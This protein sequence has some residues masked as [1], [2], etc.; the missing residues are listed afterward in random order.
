VSFENGQNG[1]ILGEFGDPIE[2]RRNVRNNARF[3]PPFQGH[4]EAPYEEPWLGRRQGRQ[5]GQQAQFEPHA[6]PPRHGMHFGDPKEEQWG[7]NDQDE[8]WF[9]PGGGRQAR[10]RPRQYQGAHHRDPY[11]QEQDG[12]PWNQGRA[13]DPRPM[14]LDFPRFKGGDPTAWV[15]RAL[16]YFHYYQVPEP[17]KVMHASYHLDEEALVWFQDCE[18]EL[19][20][21]NDFVRA[22]QIRFGPASYDDPMELLTKL[23]QTHSIAAYKSQFELTSNRVRDLSNM[24]KLSCFMSCMKDEIRLAVK[25]QGPRNLGEA[26]A[27]AKIQEEYLAT[28]KRSTRPTYEPSRGAWVQSQ[29][30][31]RAA[32][33]ENKSGDS[34]QFSA[35]PSMLVQRLTPMQMS[36]RRKK[37]LC[38]NCD[39]RWSSDHKCK[40]RKLYLMEEVED[41]EA[42]LVEIEEEEVEAELEEAKAEITLCAL[43]GS[44]SPSTMR[45]IAI[46]NGQTTVVLLDTGSTHNFMDETLA[47][48]LKLPMDGE[49]NFG[50]RVANGQVI[51]TL[52][53]CKE[54]KFKMQGLH[55]KLTFNLLE[56]GGYGIVLGTQWLSTLGMINWDFKNLMMGFMHEGKQVWLQGLKEKPNLIQGSK[57]FK[58]KATMKGLLFQIMPCEL[59]SIQEE[60]G[61]PIRE[62]VEEFPQVFEEPEG[63]PPKRNH[64]HQI[65]LKHET[66]KPTGLLQPLGIPPRPWHTISMD[67]VEGLP[68]S[69][70]QNVI[71]VI[72]D[73][74]TKYVH[75]IPLSHPCTV[76]RVAF[77][78]LQH[79]FKLHGLSSSI[80]SDRDTAFTSLFWEEL[81]R[82]QGVDLTMSSS[83]YP[84]SDEPTEVVNKS[85]EHYLRA[86]AADKPS[87]WV[88]WLP[89]AEYWFNTNYHTSTKLSPF[90]ALYGYLPPRLIE[91]VLGLTR[92]AAVE[93]LLEHR[94]QVVGLLEH[95]LVAA[96]ARMKQQ[97]DKHRSEREFEVGDWV[98]LRLQPFRQ[99]SMC[100]KLGKLSPKFYGPYKVIQRVGMVA[101]K[102]EL[103]EGACI[104]PVFHVSFLKAKLGKTITPISRIPPTDALGHLAPQPAKILE[105]RTIK[106]R[107]L[108]AVTEVLVQWE[109]EDPDDATWELLFKLQE[110][111]PHLVGK[112]F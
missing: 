50:V 83:Y 35:R 34:K 4:F 87:L 81:F 79:V 3:M 54:V 90:E 22:I 41:E 100:K 24:H 45:V 73:R 78:F 2:E 23:K 7:L 28:V 62:L 17:E 11:W 112:V 86:F 48:T 61:A 42:E 102:L 16:Q 68:T 99:K 12:P 95:N 40:D 58:G 10:E 103:P 59:A 44:T 39:E 84:Q 5:Q 74:F 80:V 53:E 9:D 110:D 64:E 26:Y 101:Y 15:Y 56:L 57:D 94:Q 14:K 97:A 19:H 92:V 96:Q 76:S 20:G 67:F 6:A 106:K 65:L 33:V 37:G 51:R 31:Q 38:Y 13:R 70:K 29:A 82:R 71:L 8:A 32:Q 1:P 108:P 63:L 75:F 49:S 109:G 105:T 91:F 89:L 77:L 43:L 72:V 104:H 93:D 111:Y 47:K 66:S 25:M 52:G 85:L 69:S 60:I 88:E 27:L 46:V 30:Q 18:H 36:E 98:F 21:W 55:L 107:R